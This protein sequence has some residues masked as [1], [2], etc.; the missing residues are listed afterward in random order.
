MAAF[1]LGLLI[2]GVVVWILRPAPESGFV[3]RSDYDLP[4]GINFRNAER[5]VFAASPDGRYF[6]YNGTGGLYLRSID[7]LDARLIPGTEGNLTTSPFFSADSQ[8]VGFWNGEGRIEK[9][10]ISGGTPVLIGPAGR[11][12]AGISWGVDDMVLFEQ[13]DGIYRV[14]SN[15]GTPERIIEATD[16]ERFS[17]PQ[18]LPDGR[19][20]LFTVGQGGGNWDSAQIVVQSVESPEDRTVVWAGSDAR[21]LSTGHLTYAL[22]DDLF[23]IAFDLDTLETRGSAVSLEQGMVRAG[24]SDS[25]NYAVSDGGSLVYATAGTGP[26]EVANRFLTWVDRTGAREPLPVPPRPYR[27]PQLS[28]DGTRLAVQTTDANGQSDIWVYDLDGST[29]MQ[30]MTGEGNN[31]NPIWTPDGER[32]TFTSDRDGQERIYW[33]LADLSGV[34]EPITE[35]EEGCQLLPESWTPDSRTLS[36]TKRGCGDNSVFILSPDDGVLTEV[37]GSTGNSAFSPDG[38]WLAYQSNG[39]EGSGSELYMQPFPATGTEVRL[40]QEGGSTPMWSRDGRELF[41][42]RFVSMSPFEGAQ[43]QFFAAVEM[44]LDGTPEWSNERVLPIEDFLVFPGGSRDYDITPDGE[45]F[46]MVFPAE[47]EPAR[48]QINTVLNWFEELKERVPVP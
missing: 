27:Q 8:W 20:I 42:R 22:A 19:G 46:L 1:A 9:I 43:S 3:S 38:Q 21:Y 26:A 32:L 4:E 35:P 34:A 7:E 25:A 40:T 29:Q 28:P 30:Q 17:S 47:D 13:P 5:N 12:A 44:T 14:S 45:Q 18:L 11:N 48:P 41:Y 15:G 10:A 39:R 23:A 31:T 24:G 33:Q 6:V 2:A 16:G 37:L 36:V